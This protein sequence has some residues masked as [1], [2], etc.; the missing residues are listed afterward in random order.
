MAAALAA[1]G[2]AGAGEGARGSRPDPAALP[3]RVRLIVLHALGHPGYHQPELRFTFF[4]PP[5]TMALWKRTFGAHWIV[6]TDGSIW[7]RRG[8]TSSPS[9][10]P[11]RFEDASDA[12]RR[13]LASE[14]APVF[15]HLHNGNS[16]TV[17]VELAHSGRSAD[18]FPDAQLRSTAFLVRTLLE[19]SG[20]RLDPSS[21]VGHKDVDRR[22]AYVRSRCARP[23]CAV[24]V[25]E[26]GQPFRRRVDPPEA[27]FAGLA[28]RGLAIPRPPGGDDELRRAEALLP[29]QRPA[30]GR[31]RVTAAAR[32]ARATRQAAP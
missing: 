22:P 2:A 16:R 6:W 29:G 11:A 30:E 27:L 12:E 26:S 9:W 13:R 5:R 19:M 3:A 15:S 4:T 14:A 31:L 10:Q 24:F 23:G 25:D 21:V 7:P 8:A 18:P 20:G 32:G 28:R 17:G 1:L